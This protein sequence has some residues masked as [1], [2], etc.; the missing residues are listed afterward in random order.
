M[1]SQALQLDEVSLNAITARVSAKTNVQPT[2][3]WLHQCDMLDIPQQNPLK[4]GFSGI[5][6]KY[7]YIY[8]YTY[9]HI[10]IYMYH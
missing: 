9:V 2:S 10:Y 4:Y 6:I 8:V 5:E 1:V 3:E 7:I